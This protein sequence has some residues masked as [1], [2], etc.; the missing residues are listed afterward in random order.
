M[1]INCL[2]LYDV[3]MLALVLLEAAI[4][5][6]Q[7]PCTATWCFNMHGY[8]SSFR[9]ASSNTATAQHK[10]QRPEVVLVCILGAVQC[11]CHYLMGCMQHTHVMC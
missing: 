9:T 2:A 3:E 6:T 5:C 11:I 7:Q 8:E 10:L 4:L 1:F